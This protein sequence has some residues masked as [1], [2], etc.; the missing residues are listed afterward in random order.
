M[1]SSTLGYEVFVA[2]PVPQALTEP[3]PNGQPHLYQP[4]AVTLVHGDHD[5]VLVDPPLTGEQ[6][7]LVGDW[8]AASGYRLTHIVATHGHGDHW[9][10]ADVLARRFGAQVLAT[11]AT[12]AQMR[13]IESSLI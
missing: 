11:T 2:D 10:T 5:A 8:V 12:I 6:A 13:Q 9:F 4:I 7:Q 3:L 1:S